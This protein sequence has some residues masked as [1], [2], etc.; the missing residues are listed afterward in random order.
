MAENQ[1]ANRSRVLPRWSGVSWWTRRGGPTEIALARQGR[2]AMRP[3]RTGIAL[4]QQ[5]LAVGGVAGVLLGIML[6][7]LLSDFLLPDYEWA[8]FGIVGIVFTLLAVRL[9]YCGYKKFSEVNVAATDQIDTL[10]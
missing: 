7:K 4:A 5:L 2:G 10:R 1:T 9:A 8:C 3:R 6:A